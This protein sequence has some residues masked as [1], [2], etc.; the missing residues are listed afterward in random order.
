MST[1]I[2]PEP[3]IETPPDPTPHPDR[4]EKGRTIVC[5]CCG[6]RLDRRG[7]LLRRGDLAKQMIEAED[8]IAALKKQLA[9][10]SDDLQAVRVELDETKAKIQPERRP[11]W[12]RDA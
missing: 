2:P 5:E 1:I 4:I 6:S 3:P 7:G 10:A 9:K 11:L 12:Q 8:I